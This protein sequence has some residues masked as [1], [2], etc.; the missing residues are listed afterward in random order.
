MLS[1]GALSFLN[2]WVLAG[3]AALPILWW[4]L[5]A[6]PPSPRR[7]VFWP[8]RLL[9]GLED[10]EREA[11]RTPWWLILLRI[12]AVAAILVGFARPVVN[13]TER[14]AAGGDGPLLILMDQGW[15]SAPD[16]EARQAAVL[17]A[18]D[19]AA[20]ADRQVLFWSLAE[21][22]LPPLADS[23]ALRRV[24]EGTEPAPWAPRR[25]AVLEALEAGSLAAPAQTLWL[26]DGIDHDGAGDALAERL[27]AAGPL[28]LMLPAGPPVAL[29]S[30]RLEEGR[31]T[32]DVLRS[33]GPAETVL[34][35]AIAADETGAE[36]RIG[37][38]Q[39][40]FAAG[41]TEALAQFDLPR[42]VLGRITRLSVVDRGS[43]GGT[44]LATGAIRRVSAAI[45]ASI[46]EGAVP[47]LTSARHYLRKAM[48]PWA[49]LS[50]S[51]T[52]ADALPGEPAALLMADFG[53]IAGPEREALEA[54]VEE[55]G[56]LIRFAGPRLASAVAERGA[57]TEETSLLPVRLRRGGRVLGGAL[58]W[59]QPKRIGAFPETSPFRGLE[60]P[61]EVDIRTQVL[62]DPAPGLD[63]HVWA[64]LDDGTPLVTGRQV[65]E[66]HVVL[67]HVTADAAWSSLPLSGLFVEM[68]GRLMVLAPGQVPEPPS[69][70]DLAGTLWRADTV[71]GADGAP[72]AAGSLAAPVEGERL[73]ARDFGS[74]VG[75]GL[76]IRTDARERAPGEAGELVLSLYEAGDA[77][78]A[79]SDPPAGAV[80]ERLGG[81]EATRLGHWFLLAALG[82]A[83]V[84]LLA[85]LWISGRLANF[86]RPAR[87]AAL[88]LAAL[89]AA[90]GSAEAQDS[91]AD[92]AAVEATAETTLGYVLTGDARVD[93]L[94]ERAMVGL[95]N[96][97]SLRTAVEPGPPVG[98]EP[99][100]DALAFYPVIYW[101][102][103]GAALPSDQGL[104][105][106]NA[107]LAS[108]GMLL[109][110]TQNGAA[111]FGAASAT[112]MRRIARA[113]NLPPL[114]PVGRDHVLTR[115]FYLLDRFPGRWRGGRVWAEAGTGRGRSD[116]PEEP[117]LPQFDRVDD[118]VS[119][120]IVGS[121]DWAAAWAVDE[122]GMPLV[123]IG[124]SGDR[125]REM[126]IRFG[127]NLVMYALTGNYKS[128]QV[129]APEVLRRLGQ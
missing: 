129:H 78:T 99:E 100:R 92:R 111:G 39:A 55:G 67:F 4:L 71:I 36:R 98:L 119:P 87:A 1:L 19:E 116:D 76:F 126:A 49:D 38:A 5:R 15:A 103:I 60:A 3:L 44:V 53:E 61:G 13:P 104:A 83:L 96:Q 30:A 34:V 26:S 79:L 54:W 9:F 62:A 56:L 110:D 46:P 40:A 24:V 28:T 118:N 123:A 74:G 2:P 70:E 120:V 59:S 50:L 48:V 18:L 91:A 42:P 25:A 109:V 125:Q 37:V 65:G 63:A 31:L 112:E 113:L 85:T 29:T 90:P 21:G 88:V 22:A 47:T 64:R 77:L 69:A 16:W 102:L 101:P 108:G 75:P 73:A 23:P 7:Q 17:G 105:R 121:A 20:D 84:D 35:A 81:A 72:R 66:G 106:L 93:R 6:V 14:L 89:G 27:A 58:S 128:D 52:L 41:E 117:V 115:S 33:G 32:A 114:E 57:T 107:Y 80:V 11:E 82:L 122:R 45:L 95:G 124:R 94:S 8:L 68:L 86:A 10:E 97:L 12:L 127:I 43:A 51:E